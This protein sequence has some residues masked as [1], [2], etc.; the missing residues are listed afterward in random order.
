MEEPNLHQGSLA[1]MDKYKIKQKITTPY[2]TQANRQVEGTNRILN[3]VI[4]KIVQLH[5]KGWPNGLVEALRPYYK[6]WRTTTCSTPYE[7]MYGKRVL[8]TIEIEIQKIIIIV[9]LGMDISKAQ[10]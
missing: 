3:T 1:L 6:R 9:Q 8:S 7:L 2:N 4:T 5:L 10:K